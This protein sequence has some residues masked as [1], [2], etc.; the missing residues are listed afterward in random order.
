MQELIKGPKFKSFY[1]A[2]DWMKQAR[3]I[4]NSGNDV[5][6]R[7]HN[8]SIEQIFNGWT[9]WHKAIPK[10]QPIVIEGTVVDN[11]VY[12][13]KREIIIQT[14]KFHRNLLAHQKVILIIH[15]GEE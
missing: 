14:E 11:G 5:V 15:Q 10:P 12:E 6:R 1:D 4:Y 8:F 7:S 13:S 3:P 2:R 9:N